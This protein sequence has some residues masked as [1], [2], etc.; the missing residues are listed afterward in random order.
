M[1]LLFD[2][3]CAWEL[4]CE[5]QYTLVLGRRKN[6]HTIN[7][8]FR[9]ED[10]P[11]V[12]GINYASDVDLGFRKN[13]YF[14]GKLIG[15]VK[16]GKI[17]ENQLLKSRNWKRIKGRLLA[18]INIQSIIE[19]NFLI[20]EFH[21]ERL[22]VLSKIEAQYVIRNNNGN[23]IFFIFLDSETGRFY[24]RSAFQYEE[25]DY[26]ANQPTLKPLKITKTFRGNTTILFENPKFETHS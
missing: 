5:T 1:G 3:A 11:H 22:N 20:A 10:F 14:G 26:F 4:L 18:A 9:K 7:L 19:G 8:S 13:E 15:L 17:S 23:N 21:P 25:I 24:C 16:R 2:A 6:L 12:I